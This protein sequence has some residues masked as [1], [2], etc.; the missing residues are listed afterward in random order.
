MSS[1]GLAIITHI[2]HGLILPVVLFVLS[3]AWVRAEVTVPTT[4]VGQVTTLIGQATVQRLDGMQ[5]LSRGHALH[6]GD[7]IETGDSGHVHIRFV[8][9]GLV[10]VRPLSRLC[11]EQYRPPRDGQP[12]AIKFRLDKGVV[13]SLTGEWGAQHKDRFRLNTPL[14]AIGIQGTDFIVKANK[15]LVAAQVISG[16][17]VM[18]PMES[19]CAI[20]LGVCQ[21]D[22]AQRLTAEMQDYILEYRPQSGNGPKLMPAYDLSSLEG[23][24]FARMQPMPIEDAQGMNKISAGNPLVAD[25]ANGALLKSRPLRWL[26]NILEW[27]VSQGTISKRYDSELA[28]GMAPTVG[29]FFIT[30]FRDESLQS[31]Y[32]PVLST[33]DFSLQQVSATYLQPQKGV[34]EAL[35]VNNGLLSVDF[36]HNTF[37]TRL[38]LNG[39]AL[40]SLTLQD[41]GS[42]DNKGYL[43]GQTAG[44]SL[45]GAFS[46]D[47]REAGYLFSKPVGLG[48][49]NGLTLWAAP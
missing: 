41:A 43:R 1:F 25:A 42:I 36:A 38:D 39:Q 9:G 21:S 27:N 11:L 5:R 19:A 14:A 45:T 23:A 26:H 37:S 2:R 28:A 15:D 10:S 7:C 30:L 31:T 35:A 12:A 33:A 20:S 8:D 46:M 22:H 18:T 24:A 34:E 32:Q 13:R 17:I 4:G 49:V 3:G 6:E 40:G 16:A 29:N 44:Q 47:G 48:S